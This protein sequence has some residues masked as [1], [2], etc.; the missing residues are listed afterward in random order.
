[1]SNDEPLNSSSKVHVQDP[2]GAATG[3]RVPEHRFIEPDEVA[4]AADWGVFEMFVP[5]VAFVVLVVLVVLVVFV[6]LVAADAFVEALPV[7]LVAGAP[8]LDPPG[9]AAVVG[10]VEHPRSRW[11]RGPHVV[12][13]ASFRSSAVSL[14]A[15]VGGAG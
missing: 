10:V 12:D 2:L 14:A 1:V 13:D 6:V 15:M 7:L 3:G 5:W 4:A 8:L 9:V 11:A